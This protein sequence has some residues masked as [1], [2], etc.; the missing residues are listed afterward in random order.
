MHRPSQPKNALSE[1]LAKADRGKREAASSVNPD[2]T[3]ARKAR[4]AVEAAWDKAE[5]NLRK[6]RRAF[7]NA[8]LHP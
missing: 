6:E 2:S 1:L 4:A 8:T 5:E 7:G 3:I